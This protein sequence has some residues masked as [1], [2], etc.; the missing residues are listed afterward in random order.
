[1][2]NAFKLTSKVIDY[3]NNVGFDLFKA[4]PCYGAG[5][6]ETEGYYFDL[7]AGTTMPV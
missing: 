5:L 7:D 6:H 1:M 2:S 3:F 4:D